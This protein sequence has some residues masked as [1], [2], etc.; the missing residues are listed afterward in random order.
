MA[1]P[2][3][4]VPINNNVIQATSN[5]QANIA[6]LQT[7]GQ[8]SGQVAQPQQQVANF[9]Q[10][11]NAPVNQSNAMQQNA[12]QYNVPTPVAYQGQNVQNMNTYQN[13][14]DNYKSQ[15]S[16]ITYPTITINT[17]NQNTIEGQ[18]QSNYA[19]AIN[20]VAQN[21]LNMRFSYNPNEDDLLKVASQYAAQN[22]FES[23]NSKGILNSSMTAE[24]VAKVIGNLIPTYEKM[25]REEFDA[26]FSRMIN[27]ANL[28]MNMDDREFTQW[29]DA[30][31]QKWKEE[32]REYARKQDA[33]ENA[34]RRT[35][36]LG[37][38]DNEAAVILG[39]SAGTLSKDA[40]EAKEAYERQ[41]AEWNRQHE[42]E[43]QTE[44]ELLKLKQD[45]QKEMYDYQASVDNRSYESKIQIQNKYG[46]TGSS[47]SNSTSS[48]TKTTS[49][50]TYE[51]VIKNRWAE[52]D[53]MDSS[54]YS[55]TDNDAVYNYLENEYVSGRLAENDFI[56]LITKYGI[57]EPSSTQNTNQTTS[58]T[59]SNSWL[60]PKKHR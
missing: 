41:I 26:S 19:D 18:Y 15:Y 28:L 13:V 31:D 38:V 11:N 60:T 55:I 10:G 24:R 34:W 8:V 35:D 20:K 30:R 29:Q 40:R 23:M 49:L 58:N 46:S 43:K 32:E 42:A 4:L 7:N 48:N 54:K 39:V 25:A 52:Q 33:L 36:E 47:N 1:T 12:Q 53:I 3:T 16:D 45:M 51:G 14:F 27:T 56:T 37:Y 2:N 22:T 44:I 57:N 21:I 50:S 9:P 5:P 6:N 59:T 17:A